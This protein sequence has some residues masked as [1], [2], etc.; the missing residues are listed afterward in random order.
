MD[1]VMTRGEGVQNP[2][3]E[4]DVIGD[5]APWFMHNLPSR[6]EGFTQPKA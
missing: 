6:S 5:T 2:I 1:L 4:A 3:N